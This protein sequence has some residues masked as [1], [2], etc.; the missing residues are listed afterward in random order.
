MGQEP[1][2]KILWKALEDHFGLNEAFRIMKD[3]H[4]YAFAQQKPGPVW[5]TIM[6]CW[7]F[8]HKGMMIGVEVDGYIHS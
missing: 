5:D 4:A 6:G 3:P 8:W 1:D 2:R 7:L